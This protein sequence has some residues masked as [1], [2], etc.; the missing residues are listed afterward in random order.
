MGYE[1]PNVSKMDGYTPGEQP[2]SLDVVKLNTNENPYPPA[3][4]IMEALQKVTAGV[5]YGRCLP[6][7]CQAEGI[8]GY[9]R[10]GSAQLDYLTP[11]ETQISN[12][13]KRKPSK[14]ALCIVLKG[15]PETWDL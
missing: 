9:F 14:R 3:A 5:L 11:P 13:R 10:N 1:R 15:Y 6:P 4:P 2:N 7:Y 8:L 12:I